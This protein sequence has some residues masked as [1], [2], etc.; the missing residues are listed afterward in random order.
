MKKNVIYVD[1]RFTH[2]R[3]T[4]KKLHLFYKINYLSKKF[5][6]LFSKK[7]KTTNYHSQSHP[8]KKIL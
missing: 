7:P 2:K 8:F 6:N 5:F 1:F 3:I 4:S